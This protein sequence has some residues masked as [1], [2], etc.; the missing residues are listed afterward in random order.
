LALPKHEVGLAVL[1]LVGARRSAHPRRL[2]EL[3]QE[4][5]G[6]RRLRAPRPVPPLL[7]RSD[8]LVALSWA[9][10][11]RLPPIAHAQGRLIL[12]LEGWQPDVGHAGRWGLRDGLAAAVLLARRLRSATP[13]DLAALMDAVRQA[14]GVPIVGVSSHGPPARRGAVATAWPEGPHPRCHVPSLRE[15][16]Q[17]ISAADRP[18]KQALQKRGRGVRPSAR[19]RAPRTA[20]AAAGMRGAG[21]AGRR[22]RTD[23]GPPPRVASGLQRHDRLTAL[24]QRLERVAHRGLSRSPLAG[25]TPS[26]HGA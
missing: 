2:P 26:S 13:D 19:Q 16:A 5:R 22:A 4:W 23:A 9:D 20:P 10:P 24:A 12:A 1:A 3:P 21:S 14:L 17:A 11:L 15:A 6:R 25:G 8:A 7:A 18:A